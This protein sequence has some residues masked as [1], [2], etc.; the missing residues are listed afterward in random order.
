MVLTGPREAKRRPA[1]ITASWKRAS[2]W[3]VA[4]C[5]ARCCR[6]TWTC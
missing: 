3:R 2:R 4:K 6:T 1:S 5:S